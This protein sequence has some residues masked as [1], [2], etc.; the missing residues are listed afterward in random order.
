[1]AD[2]PVP[3]DFAPRPKWR[4][5]RIVHHKLHPWTPA[6]TLNQKA[7]AGGRARARLCR[8]NKLIAE[9]ARERH[10]QKAPTL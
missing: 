8:I 5:Q 4:I 2:V 10:T 3:S 9:I 6:L 7:Q 1:M